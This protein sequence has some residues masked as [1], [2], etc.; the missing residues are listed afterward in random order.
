VLL[1]T[2][3]LTTSVQTALG[4]AKGSRSVLGEPVANARGPFGRLYTRFTWYQPFGDAW[5]GTA[6]VEAGQVFT[7]DVV[8]IPDTLLFRAGGDDSVRGYAYRTLGPSIDGVTTSGRS[9]FTTSLEVARPIS[10]N[11]PAY[12]WAAFVD[13]GNAA[14]KFSEIRPAYGYG[15][16]LRWRSPVGPLRVD[17]A[18][19]QQTKQVRMHL[20]VGIAF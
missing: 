5:Y 9:L 11:Y 20:S 15:V 16:G 17:L 18:Y 14:D 13:A 8:G 2:R 6:R 10:P 7:H 1:P 3:G 19:G 12:W 4:Y